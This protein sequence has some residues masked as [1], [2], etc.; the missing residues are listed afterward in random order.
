MDC[1]RKKDEVLKGYFGHIEADRY[2]NLSLN[3][4]YIFGRFDQQKIFSSDHEG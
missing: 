3:R 4:M 1:R 2:V